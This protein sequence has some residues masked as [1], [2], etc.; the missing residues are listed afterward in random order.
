VDWLQGNGYSHL[1]SRVVVVVNAARPGGPGLDMERLRHTFLSRVRAI[2]SIPF[3]GHL[4]EGAVVD[5]KF[6]GHATRQAYLELAAEVVDG[7]VDV[8]RASDASGRP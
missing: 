8:V 5:L 6:A 3:D 1:M 7:F 2:H 4:A